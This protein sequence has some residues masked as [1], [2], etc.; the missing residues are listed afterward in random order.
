MKKRYWMCFAKAVLFLALPWLL[1]LYYEALAR[2]PHFSIPPLVPDIGLGII[3]L[4]VALAAFLLRSGWI[5]DLVI[6]VGSVGWILA[7][8]EL[9]SWLASLVVF[10]CPFVL[11]GIFMASAV[12]K[13]VHFFKRKRAVKAAE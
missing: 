3:A 10:I 6:A 8:F 1:N 7:Q 9:A 13:G 5:T 12:V 11:A 2:A 4:L